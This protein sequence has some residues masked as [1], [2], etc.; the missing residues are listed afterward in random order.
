MFILSS[1][2]IYTGYSNEKP[3]VYVF[4]GLQA[5]TIS[6]FIYTLFI[7]IH[8][9]TFDEDSQSLIIYGVS[10]KLPTTKQVIPLCK[11][12]NAYGIPSDFSIFA[13]N[14][15]TGIY[16]KTR[17]QKVIKMINTSKPVKVAEKINELLKKRIDRYKLLERS[18]VTSLPDLEVIDAVMIWMY[19]KIDN[20]HNEYS[21]ITSLP[22]PCQ[23]V[24]SCYNIVNEVNK[25]GINL[26]YFNQIKQLAQIAQEGFNAIG[27]K[28]LSDLMEEANKI[29]QDNK[30]V[31]DKYSDGTKESYINLYNE[32]F[33]DDLDYSFIEEEVPSFEIS[34]VAYIRKNEIYFGE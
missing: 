27:N 23:Y 6:T 21:I 28:K 13:N 1:V 4:Y 32:D 34:L 12:V 9:I 18:T 30:P 16:I 11:I 5:L 20:W 19:N 3:F 26:L 22:K 7:P 33:F 14:Q 31:I 25:G 29:Y 24:Y 10:K 15:N 8:S 17:D 2:L